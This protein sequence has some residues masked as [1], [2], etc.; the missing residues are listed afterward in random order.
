M[1]SSTETSLLSKKGISVTPIRLLVLKTFLKNSQAF[2]LKDLEEKLF[3]SERS[4]I[5]RTLQ[6]FEKKGILHEI[7]SSDGI[8]SY[9][10]CSD[11]EHENHNDQHAHLKCRK[12]NSVFCVSLDIEHFFSASNDYQ[13]DDV[14]IF[15]NG[16]CKACNSVA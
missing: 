5:F 3:F 8:K 16:I 11:S 9:A 12:C 4:T 7:I 14:Q 6:L 2:S 1:S 15:I 10:L 13:V